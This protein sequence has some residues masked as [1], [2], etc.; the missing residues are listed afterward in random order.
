VGIGKDSAYLAFGSNPLDLV[1]KAMD[2]AG[3]AETQSTFQMNFQVG[4]FLKMASQA[5]DEPVL[6]KMAKKLM[7]DGNDRVRI[8][9]NYVENG[10]NTRFE[11]Q[12]GILSL[13]K[14][15]QESFSGGG[16]DE[17]EMEDEDF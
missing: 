12:D 4:Q 15:A 2:S 7:T 11:L 3:P 14:V 10:Y 17:E 6:K 5:N 8:S 13:I 9:S 1:K 16:M